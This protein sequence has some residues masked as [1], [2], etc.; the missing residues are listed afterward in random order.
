MTSGSTQAGAAPYNK[1]FLSVY[2]L[3]VIRLSNDYGWRCNR[4]NF[5][6]LYN[7]HLGHRHLEVGPGSGWILA[8]ADLPANLDLTLTD[9]NRNSL[10]HTA[11]RLDLPTTLIEHDVLQPFDAGVEQFDSISINYVLHCL[12]GDWSTKAAAVSNLADK[13]RPDGVLFGS[14][15]IGVDQK[16]TVFGKA[17]M[18]AYNAIGAFGNRHDDLP[19]LHT[20]LESRFEHV[21]VNMVGNVALFAARSPKRA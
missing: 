1:V 21:E 13:L 4:R 17:L 8:N 12:P 7:E 15:V 19:G 9:L 2:D 18:T 16:Y 14:T 10:D 5:V 6:Q 3:W 20:V 11:A